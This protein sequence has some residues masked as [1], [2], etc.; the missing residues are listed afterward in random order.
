VIWWAFLFFDPLPPPHRREKANVV[1]MRTV[2]H[3]ES[4]RDSP[5]YLEV[6]A[7]PDLTPWISHFRV[8]RGPAH[9][10]TVPTALRLLTDA[11]TGIVIDCGPSG[12]SSPPVFMGVMQTATVVTFAESRELIGV[13]FKPGGALPFVTSSLH[14]F[15]G[16]RV[17][18]PLLWGSLAQRMG[19]VVRSAPFR[20]QVPALENCLRAWIRRQQS[21]ASSTQATAA[22]ELALVSQAIAHLDHDAAARVRDVAAA[23]CV[24]E[25]RLERVFNRAVGVPPKVFHRM[26]RCCEAAR[27]IRDACG[28]DHHTTRKRNVAPCN[29]SA[30][31]ADAG[32]ADQAHFIREFRALTGVTPVAYA[33]EHHPVGF[34]Q[35]DG[36]RPS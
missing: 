11:C 29:W 10:N 12:L 32:Y 8:I 35:Y 30:I 15:T 36:N 14:E 23:L 16:R 7:S 1:N 31:G 17:P 21:A 26:R 2:Q 13:R 33:A 25:R 34:M 18:L 9:S 3:L 27:L 19:D 5:W 24:G 20:E 4:E 28:E 6:P 22:R